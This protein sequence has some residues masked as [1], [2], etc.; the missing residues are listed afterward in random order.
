MINSAVPRK[1]QRMNIVR[2]GLTVLSAGVLLGLSVTGLAIR[3]GQLQTEDDKHSY[4]NTSAVVRLYE[5]RHGS[6]S[7]HEERQHIYDNAWQACA[8]LEKNQSLPQLWR[9][10]TDSG[11]S[12]DAAATTIE[13]AI[14]YV[15]PQFS[16][17]LEEGR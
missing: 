14:T 10:M 12:S 1:G 9:D 13:A 2:K 7:S 8:Y 16:S 6:L 4:L 11:I 3:L 5:E 15:C 17:L